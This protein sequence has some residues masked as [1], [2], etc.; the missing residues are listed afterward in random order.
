M[1]GRLTKEHK[2]QLED[3][4]GKG[5]R[6]FE[7]VFS[8]TKDEGTAKAFHD[9]CDNQGPTV[10]V[11]YND[12]NSIYGGYAYESWKYSGGYYSDANAFLFQLAFSGNKKRN[13][14]SVKTSG[15]ALYGYSTKGPIFGQDDLWTF[16]KAVKDGNV[17]RIDGDMSGFGS[18]YDSLGTK[19]VDINNDSKVVIDIEVYK[20]TGKLKQLSFCLLNTNILISVCPS[21]VVLQVVKTRLYMYFESLG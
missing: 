8:L 19:S 14:F 17:Y 7:L 18:T 12:Q 4:I 20:V 3:W 1:S 16:N 10:T 21:C 6:T 5:S 15:N 11:V 13:K 2:K 9:K